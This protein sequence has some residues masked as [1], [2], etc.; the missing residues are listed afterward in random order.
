MALS[1]YF[2][3]QSMKDLDRVAR[4]LRGHRE[5]SGAFLNTGNFPIAANGSSKALLIKV[6]KGSNFVVSHGGNPRD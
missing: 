3:F 4:C 2:I 5:L 6:T 1:A